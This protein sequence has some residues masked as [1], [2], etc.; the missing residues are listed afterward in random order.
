MHS[1]FLDRAH[2][3][4]V[5]KL[6]QLSVAMPCVLVLAW[7]A[8]FTRQ[9]P[10]RRARRFR[11]LS[12]GSGEATFYLVGPDH[13]VK[14]NVTLGT[15]CCRFSPTTC[16]R[17]AATRRSSATPHALLPQFEV[18]ATQPAHLS[19]FLHPSRVPVST[20]NSIDATA[21][22]FDQYFNLVPAPSTVDFR[23]T[24][25]SGDSVLPASFH[26]ARSGLDCARTRR[27]HEGRVQ[28]T[29]RLGNVEEARVV[30]QVAA[31]A[32]ALARESYAERK[33]VHLETDPVRDC[34]GNAL[35]DGTVVSF[36][37]ID[38]M[39]RALSTLRS[40]KAL[41]ETQFS[42]QDP[43]RSASPAGL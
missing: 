28:V 19:F 8:D 29:A 9:P 11:F 24:P 40:R 7:P 31:E 14:R 35:P 6:W 5:L 21:F 26:P 2:F 3:R 23:I 43:R 34:S 12:Q 27:A 42:I 30:Q 37:T 15:R 4:T 16:A 22:V 1:E 39:A 17:R 13:V 10:S 38:E 33:T 36:T 25:A 20:P 18:K 41:P 32:C